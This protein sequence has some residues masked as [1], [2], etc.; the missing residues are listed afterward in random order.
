MFNSKLIIFGRI[1]LVAKR[2]SDEDYAIIQQLR[3][4]GQIPPST[5]NNRSSK[6]DEIKWPPPYIFMAI[7]VLIGCLLLG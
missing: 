5:G 3:Q 4:S 7:A 2:V 1:K 6:S